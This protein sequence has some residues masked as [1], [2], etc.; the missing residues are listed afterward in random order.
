MKIDNVIKIVLSGLF[1]LCLFRMPYGYYELVRF[2]AMA[3]FGFLAFRSYEENKKQGALLY[4]FLAIL[5]Q[6]LFKISLGR[7]IWNI[8]DVIV[9]IGLIISILFRAKDKNKMNS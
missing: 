9:G 4:L 3:S 8:I 7:E 6:P 2:L 1:F 5:F